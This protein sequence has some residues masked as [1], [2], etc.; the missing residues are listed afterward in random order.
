MPRRPR[1]ADREPVSSLP[2]KHTL[3]PKAPPK[4]MHSRFAE[5]EPES[6]EETASE[7][8][9]DNDS[10]E[11]GLSGEEDEPNFEE[12]NQD[13]DVDAPRVAQW[14]PDEFESDDS[15]DE[16]DSGD[17]EKITPRRAGP[18]NLQLTSLQDDLDS[19]PLGTL[20]KAQ[21]VLA[22]ARVNIHS[23]DGGSSGED[24]S[25]DETGAHGLDTEGKQKEKP[26]WSTKPRIDLA[27]RSSK[28]APQ[29][30]TSKRPV[31]RR[32][33]VVDVKVQQTR[34]PRFFALAGEF[35]NHKFQEQYGFLTDIYS[36]ELKTLRENLKR[37]RKLLASSPRDLREERQQEVSR[38][39][40]T[41][42]RAESSVNKDRR[43]MVEQKAL[44]QFAK[45]EREKRKTGK[46]G[47]W[48]KKSDK[49]DLL[50]HARYDALAA[51][52]GKG[53]VKKAIEKKQKKI[54]QKEKKSRPFAR[55]RPN[56]TGQESG[57]GKRPFSP[58]SRLDGGRFEKR[59]RVG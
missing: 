22:H 46:G 13:I 54:S 58:G 18:S 7:Q 55:E 50:V 25:E 42:K 39:E 15:R 31:T 33:T 20:R 49:K 56:G 51:T 8:E 53:A 43:E 9:P 17:G 28:H 24:G 45:E 57:S 37:A 29:E 32:R 4:Q 10:G 27:K 30:V 12:D 1:P 19:L 26:E 47:W 41:V 11:F 21:R 6:D 3:S 48:M 36:A 23:E 2:S 5:V 44:S 52:G 14:E 38:L 34:D 40:L 16:N 59:R 35:S